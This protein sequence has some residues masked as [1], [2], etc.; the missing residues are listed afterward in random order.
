MLK[1]AMKKLLNPELI[2]YDQ[3]FKFM[4]VHENESYQAV[5]SAEGAKLVL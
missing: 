5:S 1:P 3:F 4:Q 2:R